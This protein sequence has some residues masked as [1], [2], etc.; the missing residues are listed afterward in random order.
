MPRPHAHRTGV[1][2]REFLQVGYSGLLGLG[3]ASFARPAPAGE[4]RRAKPKAVILVFQTGAPSHIDTFDP[5][6]DATAEIRGEF[7]VIDTTVPGVKFGEHLPRMAARMKSMA[8]VRTFAHK[9]NNH[10]AAT[11]H[12]ITGAMQPGVRFD[13]PLSRDDWPCYASGVS[14][15]R[16][17]ADGIPSGVTLPTF[18]AEGPLVW[19]GQ[20]GGFLGPK[21]DPWQIDKNPN[22]PNFKVDN[23]SFP[24]GLDAS[25]LN[26]RLALLDEVNRQQSALSESLEGRKLTDQQKKAAAVLSSGAVTRAFE[27]DREPTKSRDRYGRHPF[28]QSL[29][30]ARRLVEAGVPMIQANMGRV[31][32]WDSH[33]DNFKRL[34]NDLLPPLDRAVAALHDDLAESGLMDDVMVVVTGEFG[35]A[36]KVD[37]NNAGRDH[38]A[39]CYSG[40]FFGGGV[41]GGQVIGKSDATAAYPSTVPYSPDDLGATIYH[42]LGL[43]PATELR[44]RQD[45]PVQLNRGSVI[46]SLFSGA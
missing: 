25:H 21:H 39:A 30:L 20:H 8:V 31:Q 5:K 46:Q 26:D 16:P 6:P 22:L 42:T 33:S 34:K 7:G 43:D 27:I 36:P 28:G 19:P 29:L 35:R 37:R 44:D 15:L 12:I 18:L 24:T 9:D 23:L 14:F 2:R 38:W 10:T 11:H 1:H 13:K 40:A 41:R 45:R 3:L 32:N 17:P 4:N